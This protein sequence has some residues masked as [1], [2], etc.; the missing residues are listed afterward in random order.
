MAKQAAYRRDI[1]GLR[2]VAILP[3]ILFH[4]G[5]RYA[6]G[7]FLGVD[8]FFV[9]SGYLITTHI[10]GELDAGR[11]SLSNFYERR[12]R[13]IVPAL[14]FLL[15]SAWV[16]SYFLLYPAE[17]IDFQKTVA[18][19]VLSVS[20]IY[21][22]RTTNYFSDHGS[23]LLHTWSLAVEEQFYLVMPLC[24]ML[25]SRYRRRWLAPVL[26]GLT[27]ASLLLCILTYRKFPD[28]TFYLLPQ[29]AWEL[30][31]GG[32][33]GLGIL[34]CPNVRAVRELAAAFGL[35]VILFF[36][37]QLPESWYFPGPG[38]ILPC[39]GAGMVLTAGAAGETWT[40]RVLSIKPL[41]GVG[42]ISYSTYLW[43]APLIAFLSRLTG[44]VFGRVL[45]RIFPFLSPAQS[46]TAEKLLLILGGSLALG[47]VSWRFVE[48]P[49]R[50]GKSRP[51][52]SALFKSAAAA[53]VMLLIVS[54]GMIAAKGLPNRYP[55]EA[56]AITS[57][58]PPEMHFPDFICL[59]T[60]TEEARLEGCSGL[61]PN[62][63]NWLL[64]GDSHAAH[65]DYGLN[66]VFP[67]VKTL[68][69]NLH[70]CKP[71]PEPRYGESASCAAAYKSLYS[72][73]LPH[74]HFDLIVMSANW[75]PFD[76]P[77]IQ[78]A[79][80]I[81]RKLNQPVV[82]VGPIM[83]Y[84]VPL[85]RLLADE[86]LH[87]DPTL[88]ERHRVVAFDAL[89]QEMALRAQQQWHVAYFS[90]GVFCPGGHCR[91]WS[92][93]DVPLQWDETHLTDDGS[94]IVAQAMR[95]SGIMPLKDSEVTR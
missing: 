24:L 9:I 31:L 46:I 83:R 11:F 93:R 88:A 91:E 77:R 76:I 53:A 48:Q 54:A 17:M 39:L 89:D 18:A 90:F 69:F 78:T 7:G 12:V 66:R 13:R 60:P 28:A 6:P 4:T 65:L 50:F 79:L 61:D 2:A 57:F 81:F 72:D 15:I 56:I 92:G 43:H 75:Q 84:D 45:P 38:M 67:D 27:V 85:R 59:P 35:A 49:V 70:G 47:F 20:N 37:V 25:I 51:S 14:I 52:K 82:L 58:G 10:Q 95:A 44:I 73:Y 34:R 63:Q 3:V 62:R 42:L 80:E 68:R 22:W 71:V 5:F 41:V 64:I 55:I 16:A 29:R 1:D 87:H 21:F 33:F 23:P 30:L 94:V 19:T 32:V 26:I 86:I 8:I 36:I 74:Q 40:G